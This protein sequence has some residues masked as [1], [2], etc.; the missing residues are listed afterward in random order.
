MIN[1]NILNKN[2]EQKPIFLIIC[3]KVKLSVN[4]IIIKINNY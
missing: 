1:I 4:I 3:T 2:L